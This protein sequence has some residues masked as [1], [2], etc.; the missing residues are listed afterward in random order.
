MPCSKRFF[1]VGRISL[2]TL[3]PFLRGGGGKS[4]TINQ[5]QVLMQGSAQ[6]RARGFGVAPRLG[7]RHPAGCPPSSRPCPSSPGSAASRLCQH[8]YFLGHSVKRSIA[9]AWVKNKHAKKSPSEQE[10][11]VMVV[12]V[13]G[14]G[15]N[16]S[17]L[18][19]CRELAALPSLSEG[20]L[21]FPH[22]PSQVVPGAA[23]QGRVILNN[24]DLRP[25]VSSTH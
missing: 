4:Q 15:R 16:P 3:P 12:G 6:R 2:A 5:R 7:G 21:R 18:Q 25:K 17:D 24:W 10:A 22:L 8:G 11:V 23:R 20:G 9:L 13:R 14:G 19:V 1:S